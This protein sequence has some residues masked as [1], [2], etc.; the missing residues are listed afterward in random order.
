MQRNTTYTASFRAYSA[1]GARSVISEVDDDKLMQETSGN[2]MKSE[3]REKIEAPQNYGF[4]SVCTDGDKDQEGN[5][6]AG[7]EAFISFMGGSRSFP[8][9]TVMDDRRHRLK[10]LEKGDVSMFRQK[11]D[12]QQL[13]LTKKGG[14]WSAPDDKTVRMQLVEKKQQ[15]QN[16]QGS[17]SGGSTNGSGQ[18]GGQ[19][20]Q[21]AAQ[22]PTGQEAVYK[23]GDKSYRYVDVTKTHTKAS[24][25]NVHLKLSDQKTYVDVNSD[26]NVYLGAAKGS[27]MNTQMVF[28]SDPSGKGGAFFEELEIGEIEAKANGFGRVWTELGLSKN[29]WALVAGGGGGG[30]PGGGG[31]GGGVSE[32]KPPLSMSSDG[33]TMLLNMVAPLIT[34]A[35][36]A[37]S[38]A[39]NAPLYV[40]GDGK[41]SINLPPPPPITISVSDTAPAVANGRM[42]FDSTGLE[43]Y[44]GYDDGTSVQWVPSTKGGSASGGG[45]T[46]GPPVTVAASAPVVTSGS[47]WFD[48]S[49]LNLYIGYNDGTSTQWVPASSAPT[50]AA[51]AARGV[52]TAVPAS[53]TALGRTGEM[54][55]DANYV[56]VCVATNRWKRAALSTW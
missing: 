11:D 49:S 13:H 42:W 15:Q 47:L 40:G 52:M 51:S 22:K 2:F 27:S 41:L 46:A 55:C 35:A 10:K 38:L 43:L 8:V 54:A 5:L 30:P 44:V 26:K 31:G 23:D 24:G 18:S 4:T 28:R 25:E 32:A 6:S 56:Y 29:V 16:Q 34:S 50:G 7:P 21:Q 20:Q 37:L 45:G 53:S 12:Q 39:I 14:Y 17:D 19:G 33:T 3:T 36:G 48:S 9:C 1:G